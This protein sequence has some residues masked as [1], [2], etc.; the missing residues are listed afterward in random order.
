M[1]SSNLPLMARKSSKCVLCGEYKADIVMFSETDVAG[2]SVCYLDAGHQ[3]QEL[4]EHASE[5]RVRAARG[6]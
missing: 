6:S 3:L 5:V 2:K 1:T 4:L